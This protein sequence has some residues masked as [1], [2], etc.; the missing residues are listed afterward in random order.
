MNV[1][2]YP[3]EKVEWTL[4]AIGSVSEEHVRS[5]VKNCIGLGVE[6]RV[7]SV[8]GGIPCSWE[9][10]RPR[11]E[12]MLNMTVDGLL[13]N[14]DEWNEL[15]VGCRMTFSQFE[16]ERVDLEDPIA[17][18]VLRHLNDAGHP[19]NGVIVSLDKVR[20]YVRDR[21]PR[22]K[23]ICSQIRPSVEKG[24]GPDKDTIEYYETLMRSHD[25]VVVNPAKAFDTEF[26]GQLARPDKVEFIVNHCCPMNCPYE[27]AHYVRINKANDET[28]PENVPLHDR[29]LVEDV[30]PKNKLT[31]LNSTRFLHDIINIPTPA[32]TFDFAGMIGMLS[33]YYGIT[34]F[35][36]KGREWAW[37]PSFRNDLS[38]FVYS[39]EFIAFSEG[40]F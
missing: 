32:G 15:G 40:L 17:N 14:T 30:C 10:G 25:L 20:D 27:K 12:K 5:L 22:L 3:Y 28:T 1:Y 39:P 38:S 11:H 19:E 21:Y 16:E 4:G 24:F 34:H 7:K 6:N 9:A 33:N 18:A 29:W 2:A 36:L 37:N 26:L 23:V 35:K 31:R 13:R 8:F